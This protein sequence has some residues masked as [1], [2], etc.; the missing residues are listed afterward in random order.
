MSDT[1]ERERRV[2]FKT[3]FED[4]FLV[5]EFLLE[6]LRCFVL[7]LD[8]FEKALHIAMVFD[9]ARHFLLDDFHESKPT[10]SSCEEGSR[11]R[12][13]LLHE[14]GEDRIADVR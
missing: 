9:D 14:F 13:L 1:N 8:L 11:V 10:V 7:V 12:E 5:L 3:F 6:L 4:D 2:Y